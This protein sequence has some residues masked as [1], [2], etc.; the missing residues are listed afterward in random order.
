M[1]VM[2]VVDTRG[3]AFVWSE[4]QLVIT[5]NARSPLARP[6][7]STKTNVYVFFQKSAKMFHYAGWRKTCDSLFVVFA[8]VFLVTRLLV[9]PVR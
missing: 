5:W 3:V 1:F 8:V 2:V 7:S 6:K 9:L 4:H